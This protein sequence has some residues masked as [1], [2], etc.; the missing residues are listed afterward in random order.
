[1]LNLTP[2]D[3]TPD[4][5]QE[6]ENAET[7]QNQRQYNSIQDLP[8][9]LQQKIAAAMEKMKQNP[10][11]FNMISSLSG[12]SKTATQSGIS[13][14]PPDLASLIQKAET[15]NIIESQSIIVS[16]AGSPAPALSSPDTG[17][18]ASQ[19]NPRTYAQLNSQR[20]FS[21]TY[22]PM[23]KGDSLRKTIFVVIMV[24]LIGYLIFIYGFKGVLPF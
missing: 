11:L 20:N 1:M 7:K 3:R 12:L 23:V 15:G 19:S 8:P 18:N 9:E 4:S 16:D 24:G 6:F 14:L 2:G 13:R 10:G 17:L 21:P 22:D 5:P